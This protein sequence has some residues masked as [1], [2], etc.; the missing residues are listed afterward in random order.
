L[1]FEVKVD[2][3]RKAPPEYDLCYPSQPGR[4]PCAKAII[5]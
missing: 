3:K 1:C 4:E 5:P 2:A